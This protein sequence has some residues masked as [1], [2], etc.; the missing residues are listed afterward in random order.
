MQRKAQGVPLG[1]AGSAF[2][3]HLGGGNSVVTFDETQSDMMSEASSTST[4]HAP[5]ASSGHKGAAAAAAH[6]GRRSRARERERYLLP[7]EAKVEIS[8][9]ET[10]QWMMEANRDMKRLEEEIEDIQVCICGSMLICVG[11][12]VCM[13]ML[14]LMW[15]LCVHMCGCVCMTLQL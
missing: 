7:L 13:C 12:R 11:F 6:R 9:E 10:E 5:S 15:I 2:G 1:Q 14:V 3:V 4:S 8:K